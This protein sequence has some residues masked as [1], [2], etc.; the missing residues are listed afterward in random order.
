[1]RLYLTLGLG[2]I[3]VATIA[4][5]T[6]QNLTSASGQPG[7]TFCNDE[8]LRPKEPESQ[9]DQNRKLNTV[10]PTVSAKLSEGA[11]N[12]RT[13]QGVLNRVEKARYFKE[14]DAKELETAMSATAAAWYA[15]FNEA[16]SEAQEASKSEGKEGSVGSLTAFEREA[17]VQVEGIRQIE[18][19]LKAIQKRVE[20]KTYKMDQ[21]L[22]QSL[23][24]IE[25]EQIK[26]ARPQ[27]SCTGTLV[28]SFASE[29]S[30]LTDAAMPSLGVPC[31]SPCKNKQWNACLSCIL[32]KLPSA[33]GAWNSFQSC[34]NGASSPWKAVKQAACL[35]AFGVK[36]A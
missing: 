15:A 36:L 35:L 19:R 29:G 21:S 24:Q 26:E 23:N 17:N 10:S 9:R 18:S 1:M 20:N 12:I 32:S 2:L 34:W 7:G 31:L 22:N 13:L 16:T 5:Q 4:I 11:A 8:L 3:I 27:A 33:V 28:Y 6:P 30:N 25:R 14:P